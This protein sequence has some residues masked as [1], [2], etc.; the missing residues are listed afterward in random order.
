MEKRFY[1][2]NV[3]EVMLYICMLCCIKYVIEQYVHMNTVLILFIRGKHFFQMEEY[4]RQ[5]I[6][7]MH[8]IR[9]Q[10]LVNFRAI[11]K[12]QTY[13]YSFNTIS[14]E[15]RDTSLAGISPLMSKGQRIIMVHARNIYTM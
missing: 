13:R 7:S 2:E 10:R 5:A 11:S 15:W 8:Q 9:A 12:D 3:E 1:K 4:N 6:V 14:Y